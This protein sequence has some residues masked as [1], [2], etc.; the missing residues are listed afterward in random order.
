MCFPLHKFKACCRTAWWKLYLKNKNVKVAIRQRNPQS[1]VNGKWTEAPAR[2]A[3]ETRQPECK[4]NR[5]TIIVHNVILAGDFAGS[6][7]TL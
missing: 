6:A 2:E 3:G 4:V 1:S 5:M 7:T